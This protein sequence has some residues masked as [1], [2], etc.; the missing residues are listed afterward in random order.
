MKNKNNIKDELADAKYSI[1]YMKKIIIAIFLAII[2][3]LLLI[4]AIKFDLLFSLAIM[5]L[6]FIPFCDITK[7]S[8]FLL[9]KDKSDNK[10]SMFI[11]RINI[12]KVLCIL[13]FICLI[14]VSIF[15][16]M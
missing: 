15:T 12:I 16:K 9:N 6:L 4:P 13:S 3:I 7:C 10:K 2:I 14:F 1:I 8:Y 5:F 11:K